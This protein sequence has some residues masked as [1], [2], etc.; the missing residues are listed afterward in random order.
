MKALRCLVALSVGIGG[1]AAAKDPKPLFASSDVLRITMKGPIN[2]ASESPRAAA[3]IN[4]AETLPITFAERGITRRQKDV[5]PFPPLRVTFTQPPPETSVFAKQG[6]LKLVT[7]CRSGADFQQFVLL[8][9]A[10]Y[11]MFNRLTPVSFGARLA[12]IDYVGDNGRPI[13]SRYGFFIEDTDDMAKRN[14]LKEPK[15]PDRVPVGM[16]NAAYAGR[17]AMFQHML[18]N[19][20]WSMRAGPAGEG[21]CHNGKL[22]GPVPGSTQLAPVPYDFDFSGMVGAPYATPPDQLPIDNVRTRFYRGYC[23]HNAQALQAA[24]EMRSAR[25]ELLAILASTPGLEERAKTRATT[26]L[27]RFFADIATDELVT[28]KVFKSCL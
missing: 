16:L 8:E 22:V 12:L 26:Y 11:K 5:C 27:E 1:P 25:G 24:R 28:T 15:T 6:R 3:I 13:A 4:G 2:S 23:S 17:Y 10:A 14:G 9:Y 21:C 7:H 18:G 19:H 20:D